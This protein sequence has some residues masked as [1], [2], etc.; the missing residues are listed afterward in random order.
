[1]FSI[2]QDS[3]KYPRLGLGRVVCQKCACVADRAQEKSSFYAV[4]VFCFRLVGSAVLFPLFI[5]VLF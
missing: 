1:M 4:D 5:A 3:Y 2:R